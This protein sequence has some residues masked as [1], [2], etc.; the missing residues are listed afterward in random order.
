MIFQVSRSCRVLFK[1]QFQGRPVQSRQFFRF[2]TLRHDGCCTTLENALFFGGRTLG[3]AVGI[4]GRQPL[5]RQGQLGDQRLPRHHEA[6]DLLV[7]RRY[8]FLRLVSSH[9]SW[10]LRKRQGLYVA[11]RY[12]TL[13]IDSAS[14]KKHRVFAPT[15]KSP[16]QATAIL[17]TTVSG[18]ISRWRSHMQAVPYP[19][20]NGHD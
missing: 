18:F 4:F 6:A 12:R 7:F 2:D 8:L 15:S 17:T 16:Q 3:V 9:L 13:G 1:K 14:E 19:L 5:A 10:I 20:F 11:R